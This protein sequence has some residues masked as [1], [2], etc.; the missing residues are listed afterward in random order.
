[1]MSD[2]QSIGIDATLSR[3]TETFDNLTGSSER[4]Y[5]ENEAIK[6][7]FVPEKFKAYTEQKDNVKKND[8]LTIYGDV[9][10]IEEIIPHTISS[11][12]IWIECFLEKNS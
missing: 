6:V 4:T 8:K 2:I 11:E 9:Y 10:L 12:I 1:M 5:G 3:C 7:I